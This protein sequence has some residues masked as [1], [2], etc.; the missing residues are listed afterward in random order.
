MKKILSGI[1]TIIAFISVLLATGLFI[2]RSAF[3]G[4]SM[5][6]M[7]TVALEDLEIENYDKLLEEILGDEYDSDMDKYFNSK[8]FE[9]ELGKIASDY[10]LYSAN[11]SEDE[12]SIDELRD[13]VENAI[14]KYEDKEDENVDTDMVDE[15]FDELEYELENTEVVEEEEVTEVLSVIFST[16]LL[17]GSLA[18][19]LLCLAGIYALSKDIKK[20]VKRAGII[21]IIDGILVFGGGKLITFVLNKS[22]EIDEITME[23]VTVI[24]DLVSTSGIICIILG[25]VLIV[26]AKTVLKNKTAI[27]TSNE[28]IQ[29]L[30]NSVIK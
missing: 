20:T 23:L 17:F 1:L 29:N 26:V 5:G 11:V 8:K 19:A 10:L 3:S 6:K 15:F 9:K 2:A 16:S 30:D 13:L 24:T 7:M 14:E 25:I 27:S 18:V 28:A 12:P 22:G 4:N 21:S